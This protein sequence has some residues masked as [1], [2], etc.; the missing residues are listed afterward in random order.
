VRWRSAADLLPAPLR[1]SSPDAPEARYGQKRE[2]AW[3]G[4]TVHVTDTCDDETPNLITDVPTPPATP[5]DVAVLPTIQAHLATRQLTPGEQLVDA[6]SVTADHRLTS[7]T[8]HGIDLMGPVADDQRWPG[9]AG[10]GFAA[11]RCVIDWDAKDAIGPPGQRRVVW[12]ERP[13][14]HSHATVRMA[15]RKPVWG[16][17]ASRADCPRAATA[18]RALVLHEREH[19][20][21][22]QS[23]RVRQQTDAFKPA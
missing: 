19:D 21:A 6:G 7:R 3:T 15:F 8:A 18:P 9:Q 22:L 11:A 17:C 20:T 10:N 16:A 5:S 13:D 12:L 1:L 2:T 14:R 4:D 23:A